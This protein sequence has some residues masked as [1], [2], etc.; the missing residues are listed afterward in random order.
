MGYPLNDEGDFILD[1]DASDV[2]IVFCT[3]CTRCRERVIDYASRALNK[4]ETNFC[5]TEKE[6]LAV[7]L[8]HR[9]F[10]T[11]LTRQKICG[12]NRPPGFSN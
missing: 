2:G 3:R 5:I 10:Q 12:K 11:I 9:V 6:L 1:V 7:R 4:A 8:F